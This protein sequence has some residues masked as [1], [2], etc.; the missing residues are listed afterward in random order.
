M[1]VWQGDGSYRNILRHR[2]NY[3]RSSEELKVHLVDSQRVRLGKM[4]LSYF[5]GEM[6][7]ESRSITHY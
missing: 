1:K 6:D 2:M 5:E 3:W 4:V 7:R